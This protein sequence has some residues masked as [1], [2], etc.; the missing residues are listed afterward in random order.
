MRRRGV[1]LRAKISMGPKLPSNCEMKIANFKRYCFEKLKVVEKMH[2]ENMDEVPVSTDM[3]SIYNL[4][5]KVMQ[6][7]RSRKDQFDCYFVCKTRK[8]QS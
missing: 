2:M 4:D 8:F 3:P 1:S 7:V 6:D 5:C